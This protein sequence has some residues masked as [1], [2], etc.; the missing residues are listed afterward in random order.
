M[1]RIKGN[2][3]QSA[4]E[5]AILIAVVVAALLAMQIYIKRGAM[6][7]LKSASD[8]IGSQFSPTK[9]QSTFTSSTFRQSKETVLT[10]GLTNSVLLA[11]ETSTKIGEEKITGTLTNETLFEGR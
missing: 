9:T 4:L 1:L 6:G 8:D 10:N 11:P 5:Y 3:G 7:R 2:K